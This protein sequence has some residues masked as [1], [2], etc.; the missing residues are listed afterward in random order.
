[1]AA[2]QGRLRGIALPKF[3]VDTPG[4]VG[5]VPLVPY[6][7]VAR[8]PGETDLRTFRGVVTYYDPP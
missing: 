3:I 2:L 6:A 4:V 7:V 8:R 5:N 1:M